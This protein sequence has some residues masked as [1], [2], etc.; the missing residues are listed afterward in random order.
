MNIREDVLEM[1]NNDLKMLVNLNIFDADDHIARM[2]YARTLK[3]PQ[4]VTYMGK[5]HTEVLAYMLDYDVY[6]EVA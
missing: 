2:D 3:L 4:L 5:T 1:V 6:R